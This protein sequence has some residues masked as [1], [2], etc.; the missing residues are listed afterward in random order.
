M[1]LPSRKLLVRLFFTN[2]RGDTGVAWIAV[3]MALLVFMGGYMVGGVPKFKPIPQGAEQYEL[4]NND[5]ASTTN[6]SAMQLHEVSAKKKPH[7][8]P[9]PDKNKQNNAQDDPN[10]AGQATPTPTTAPCSNIAVDFLVDNSAS[11]LNGSKIARVKSLMQ[12]YVRTLPD[13]AL[14]GIQAFAEPPKAATDIVGFTKVGPQRD[15]IITKIDNALNPPSNAATYMREGF[16]L[17]QS[18]LAAA[19]SQ[20]GSYKFYLVLISDGVPEVDVCENGHPLGGKCTFK[21]A[22][23]PNPRNYDLGEDPTYTQLG[24][25]N[26]PSAIKQIGVEIFSVGIFD[27]GDQKVFSQLQ[28]LLTNIASTQGNFYR[29]DNSG[30]LSNIFPQLAQNICK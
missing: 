21:S 11:M 12:E 3:I 27:E 6:T 5:K 19:K 20:N 10:A 30:Q 4:T 13:N 8:V 1:Q 26:I 28:T 24:Q 7:E 16:K 18:K 9:D 23:N 25:P 14:I 29:V 2:L 22:D 15:N 17:A